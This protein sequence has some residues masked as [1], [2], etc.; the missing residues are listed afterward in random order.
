VTIARA[1]S[2]HARQRAATAWGTAVTALR[3]SGAGR[4]V[5]RLG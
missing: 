3:R 2:D 5:R 4:S 1:M